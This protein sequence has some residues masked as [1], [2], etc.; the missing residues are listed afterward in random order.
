MNFHKESFSDLIGATAAI[1]CAVSNKKVLLINPHGYKPEFQSIYNKSNVVFPSLKN[2]IDSILKNEDAVG[3]WTKI[4]DKFVA[5]N[6]GE[7]INR[8][9]KK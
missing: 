8:I 7:E 6:D 9:Q 4:I 3:D 2:A 5:F 1:E